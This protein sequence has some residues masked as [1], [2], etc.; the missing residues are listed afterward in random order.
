MALRPSWVSDKKE[1]NTIYDVHYWL[2]PSDQNN[3]NYGWYTVE[4]LMLWAVNNG[5]IPKKNNQKK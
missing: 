3:D 2:N 1:A 5:P 4:D